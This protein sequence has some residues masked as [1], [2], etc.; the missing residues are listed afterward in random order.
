[1]KP[2]TILPNIF[3]RQISITNVDGPM[4]GCWYDSFYHCILNIGDNKFDLERSADVIKRQG[5]LMGTTNIV[6]YLTNH[7]HNYLM[8][9]PRIAKFS[10]QK[11]SSE[12]SWEPSYC[13]RQQN[14]YH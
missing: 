3:L 2:F 1:M 8:V 13:C 14:M 7:D 9:E 10:T 11:H 5:E 12:S 4:D 6:N